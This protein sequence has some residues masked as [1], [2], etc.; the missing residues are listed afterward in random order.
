MQSDKH[1]SIQDGEDHSWR[2][3]LPNR[4]LSFS[5]VCRVS[6]THEPTRQ[7]EAKDRKGTI[8]SS[9][10]ARAAG[11]FLFKSRRLV[12]AERARSRARVVRLFV[13]RVYEQSDEAVRSRPR[14]SH[15]IRIVVAAWFRDVRRN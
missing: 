6:K 14:R 11:R 5:P 12:V 8:Q 13:E 15:H 4:V 10:R 9:R 2:R 1:A 7:I 3:S